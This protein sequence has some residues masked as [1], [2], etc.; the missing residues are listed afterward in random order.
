MNFKIA[1][2]IKIAS[3]QHTF[4]LYDSLKFAIFLM[5]VKVAFTVQQSSA[6]AMPTYRHN[7]GRPNSSSARTERTCVGSAILLYVVSNYVLSYISSDPFCKLC[8]S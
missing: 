8:Y 6:Q 2:F 1:L 5:Q 7:V 3:K 4:M